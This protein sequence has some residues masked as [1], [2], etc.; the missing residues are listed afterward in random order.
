LFEA[1]NAAELAAKIDWIYS[2]PNRAKA[3]GLEGRREFDRKYTAEM[4]YDVLMDIYQ[5]VG[6]KRALLSPSY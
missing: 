2:E 1:G 3:L 5:K 4:N 6:K